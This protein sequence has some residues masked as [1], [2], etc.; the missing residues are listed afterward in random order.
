MASKRCINL[1]MCFILG[2][3]GTVST[4]KFFAVFVFTFIFTL[5][6]CKSCNEFPNCAVI[7]RADDVRHNRF[8]M[9]LMSRHPESLPLGKELPA[10]P[11]SFMCISVADT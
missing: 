4:S 8:L 3:T 10:I 5:T 9:R 2:N 1:L 6:F 7:M 11:A